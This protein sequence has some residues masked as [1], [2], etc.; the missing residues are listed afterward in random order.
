MHLS[1]G[2]SM[3]VCLSVEKMMPVCL[4]AGV[5]PC[6]GVQLWPDSYQPLRTHER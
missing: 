2:Q 1:A 5:G 6:N 4:S 3:S